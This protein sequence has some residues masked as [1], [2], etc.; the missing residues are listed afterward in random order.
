[1]R[2]RRS[3][4]GTMRASCSQSAG[5]ETTG[6]AARHLC[7]RFLIER[8][9]LK[10][11]RHAERA[12]AADRR[13][14]P[15][16]RRVRGVP[17]R[18]PRRLPDQHPRDRHRQ[19]GAPPVVRAD[20][21]PH[22]R[23]AT[24][25]CAAAASITGSPIPT[26]RARRRSS[27]CRAGD[28]AEATARAV[29]AAVNGLRRLPLVKAPGIA[30]AVDWARAAAHARPGRRRLAGRRSA[31]RS[32]WCSRTRRTSSWSPASSTSFSA[33]RPAEASAMAAPLTGARA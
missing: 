29:V 3:T 31:A 23:A 4:S 14:R 21:E 1:M 22:A 9:L 10:A 28:V 17:A 15:R 8:P 2:A 11:L 12:G 30:E 33:R 13:D 32:A 5:A 18:I 6:E 26:R 24:K 16:R 7:R 19:G 27:C 20:L 25:R